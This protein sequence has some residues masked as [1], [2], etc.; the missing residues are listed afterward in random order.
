MPKACV[1]GVSLHYQQS[2][3]GPDLVLIH[4][5]AANLAFWF[6]RIVPALNKRHRVT[7]YDMRGH[8]KSGTPHWC[9]RS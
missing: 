9:P 8:G 2:G 4:G 6:L 1:N 5:L 3:Q 7:V